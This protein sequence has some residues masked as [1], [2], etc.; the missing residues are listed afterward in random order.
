MRI[1]YKVVIILF[2]PLFL[3]IDKFTL[4]SLATDR[5]FQREQFLVPSLKD[6]FE[7]S[8]V[9][10]AQNPSLSPNAMRL[11]NLLETE[12]N[13]RWQDWQWKQE[14]KRLLEQAVNQDLHML[15]IFGYYELLE[16]A[17]RYPN[18]VFTK[19]C[20][21]YYSITNDDEG[22][23]YYFDYNF[24]SSDA[25]FRQPFVP[26]QVIEFYKSFLIKYPGHPGSDDAAYRVARA[27]EFQGDYENALVWYGKS[28][29][30]PDEML[31]YAASRRMIFI[32]D[33]LMSSK[34]IS[35]FIQKYPDHSLNI[36]LEYSRAVHLIRE[37]QIKQA[38][39]ELERFFENHSKNFFAQIWWLDRKR[40]E[41]Q[42]EALKKLEQIKSQPSSDTSLY[43]EAAFWFH[44]SL[45]AYN[46]LSGSPN[47]P[48]K[49]E[50][51]ISSVR[52]TITAELVKR[53]NSQFRSTSGW[54]KSIELFK[55][56]LAK[57][58]N[59]KLRSKAKY[60]IGLAY[61]KL[62]E[63]SVYNLTLEEEYDWQEEAI[64]NFNEFVTEF[65]DSS[66]A[67]DALMAIANLSD[68]KSIEEQQLRLVVKNYPD[69]DRNNE[70]RKR[71]KAIDKKKCHSQN[72][73]LP[74]Q[75]RN[76]RCGA[77]D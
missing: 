9:D 30:L 19:A 41:K 56:L 67:D 70:A 26:K 17:K 77:L 58:P 51:Q 66:M 40:F 62:F 36:L 39:N 20:R 73:S 60:S 21:E 27:Y 23:F 38:R 71:L 24:G 34:S 3:S 75:L 69:G 53:A 4:A 37:G 65:P 64:R 47:L 61:T 42:I 15:S 31:T 52:L 44:N 45:T 14:T 35:D 10:I 54:L 1:N 16:L 29:Q 11:K 68:E 2:F 22:Y 8:S 43:Q 7:G 76:I 18:S 46:L 13:E 63:K 28:S 50:G 72:S 49:W 59:S 57:Y 48:S 32:A 12:S 6:T 25:I 74:V 55:Q 5:K 33:Y